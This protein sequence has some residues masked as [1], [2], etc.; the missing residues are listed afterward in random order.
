MCYILAT[1]QQKNIVITSS[2]GQQSLTLPDPSPVAAQK[3]LLPQPT[4][5]PQ[6]FRTA[7]GRLVNIQAVSQAGKQISVRKSGPSTTTSGKL[8]GIQELIHTLGYV[9]INDL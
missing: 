6:L 8:Y 2:S 3:L 5:K 1:G 7:D 4:N 9:V